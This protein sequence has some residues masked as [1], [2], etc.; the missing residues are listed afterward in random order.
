M[1]QATLL[2]DKVIEET[3]KKFIF[4]IYDA[5]HCWY[6]RI[7]DPV[8]MRPQ[9]SLAI[10][11][12]RKRIAKEQNQSPAPAPTVK[13]NKKEKRPQRICSGTMDIDNNGN[14]NHNQ[15]DALM[16]GFD[17]RRLKRFKANDNNCNCFGGVFVE[18]N[19]PRTSHFTNQL[20]RVENF[21]RS[22]L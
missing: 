8:E 12:A 20:T 13:A 16:M 2:I 17:P 6:K 18:W 19:I 22:E 4:R 5:K 14:G 3:S 15:D 7:I 9:I 21:A 11:Q 1:K 10:R